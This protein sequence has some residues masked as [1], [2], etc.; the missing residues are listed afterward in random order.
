MLYILD[1]PSIG[2]HQR[3]NDKLIGTLERLRDLGNTVVVVEHDEQMMRSSDWLVDMG[4]GAG[5]HGGHVVAEGTAAKVMR[6]KKSIT[7]QYLSGTRG[8]PVPERRVSTTTAGSRYS[9]RPRT[10]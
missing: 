5:E 8:I 6:N 7:G 4:P 9:A 1:E 3:D 2:L 10:T